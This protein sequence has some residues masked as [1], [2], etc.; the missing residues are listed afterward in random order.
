VRGRHRGGGGSPASGG[1][2]GEHSGVVLAVE[3]KGVAASA[4]TAL[5]VGHGLMGAQYS[6][7]SSTVTWFLRPS[8][9]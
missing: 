4:H 3:H 1:E 5:D 7:S 9:T 8:Q 6:R 2:L